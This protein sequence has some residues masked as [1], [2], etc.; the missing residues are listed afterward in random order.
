MLIYLKKN[1][2]CQDNV[3]RVLR[4]SLTKISLEGQKRRENLKGQF[5]KQNLMNWT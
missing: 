2:D 3:P 1:D 4:V 5:D